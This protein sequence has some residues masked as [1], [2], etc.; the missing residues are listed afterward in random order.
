[1]TNEKLCLLLLGRILNRF[2]KDIGVIDEMLPRYL[3]DTLQLGLTMLG[4]LV[5]I[6]IVNYWMMIPVIIIGAILM[7]AR[8][9]FVDTMSFLKRY[10]GISESYFFFLLFF[11]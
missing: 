5:L 2:S 8:K 7:I 4:V 10:E 9:Y 3:L 6:A 1:M 11:I